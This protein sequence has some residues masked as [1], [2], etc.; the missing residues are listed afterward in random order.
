MKKLTW[1]KIIITVG[2]LV[3]LAATSH[4]VHMAVAGDEHDVH[5]AHKEVQATQVEE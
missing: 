5:H 4:L 1:K 2:V 3:V